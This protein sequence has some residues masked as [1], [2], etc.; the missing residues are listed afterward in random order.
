[1][2]GVNISNISRRIMFDDDDDQTEAI[3]EDETM[4]A[5]NEI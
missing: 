4:D 3:N 2:R 5:S 1:M